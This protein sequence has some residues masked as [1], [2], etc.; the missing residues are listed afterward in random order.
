VLVPIVRAGIEL[1]RGRPAQAITHLEVV[2]PYELGFIAALAP[3][4]LRGLSF[5]MLGAGPPALEQFQRLLDH[6]GSDP[7]S[8][9]VA[10]AILGAARAHSVAGDVPSSLRAYERFL[11][12]WSGADPDTPVVIEA[13]HE[14]ERV[15]RGEL[16]TPHAVA[17]R[18]V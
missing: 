2:V 9:F 8:P 18:A 11:D 17:D 13:R 1:A 12:E 6:R 14:R 5:L 3:V 10:V 15:R 4:Y 7:F 16:W